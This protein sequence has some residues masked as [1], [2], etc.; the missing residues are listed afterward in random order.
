MECVC[1]F[2]AYLGQVSAFVDTVGPDKGTARDWI[3]VTKKAGVHKKA[4][5]VADTHQMA[6]LVE[7][8]KAGET[9]PSLLQTF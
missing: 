9:K 3:G 6:R 8:N 2:A 5:T 1:S 7:R 4:V